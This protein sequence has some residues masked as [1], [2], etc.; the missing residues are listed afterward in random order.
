MQDKISDLKP[1]ASRGGQMKSC[2]YKYRAA[3]NESREMLSFINFLA[4][5]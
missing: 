5:H 3:L 4:V 2:K 1:D